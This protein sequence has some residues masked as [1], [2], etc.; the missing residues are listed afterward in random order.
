MDEHSPGVHN[1]A[2]IR[3]DVSEGKMINLSIETKVA[4]GLVM[5]IVGAMAQG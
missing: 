3:R 1:H 2:E 5:L 4:T